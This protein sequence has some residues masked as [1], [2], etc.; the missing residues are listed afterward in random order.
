M[1][2]FK[3]KLFIKA[4]T[5]SDNRLMLFFLLFGF[6]GVLPLS[7]T[8][9][10]R[11]V[12]F[13]PAL[14]FFGIAFA[15]FLAN[16]LDVLLSKINNK[17]FNV[18]KLSVFAFLIATLAVSISLIGKTGRD[19]KILSE[20]NKIGMA[21]GENK[22]IGTTNEIYEKWDFQFYLLRYYN[23]TLEPAP[24]K[25]Q[26]Y[27]LFE[28]EIIKE[29]KSNYEKINVELEKYILYKKRD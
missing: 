14:P 9:V 19:E 6:C 28:K 26:A 21:I 25:Q 11:A 27:K 3:A 24:D 8:H 22:L 12:Y 17:T 15:I 23:I 7:F 18:I 16:G 4:L 5:K 2:I 13:V 20:V 1:M 10:Q 29:T